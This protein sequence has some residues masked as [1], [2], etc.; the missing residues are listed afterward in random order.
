VASVLASASPVEVV[1]VDNASTDESVRLLR[2]A[3]GSEP[4]L[5]LVENR[6]NLGFARA[7]NQG[8][9]RSNGNDI[10]LLNPD[11][12]LPPHGIARLRAALEAHPGAGMA[13]PL[14]VSP[15]GREQNGC[16]RDLPQLGTAFS[17]AFAVPR[18]L[19]SRL[20]GDFV[21]AG[22]PL[23]AGPV[24]VEAISGACM[25]V[26]KAAIDAVGPLDEG[27]FLHCE[28]LDWCARFHAA[29]FGVLFV[30]EVT[31]VHD[32]GVSCR[33]RPIFAE[34]HKHRGMLRYYGRFLRP[35]HSAV[36]AAAVATGIGLRFVGVALRGIGARAWSRGGARPWSHG[37]T[38]H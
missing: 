30:P 28:D 1:V 36:A 17:H 2:E 23:P 21:H 33:R 26:R 13:G 31:V 35:R 5:T 16:R 29:G 18:P 9:V 14:L 11:A 38:S 15:D 24:P 8:L 4:R 12:V 10:L 34:W 3:H 7:C 22:E 27:Y 32:M 19:R 25:L 20:G 6:R 37:R